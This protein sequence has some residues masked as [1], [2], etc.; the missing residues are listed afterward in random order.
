MMMFSHAPAGYICPF[1]LL[2]A[3][4]ENEH[5]LS[6]QADVF[7]RDDDITAFIAA[8][9]YPNN[10]GHVL[11]IPN[12]HVENIYTLP[13]DLTAKIHAFSRRV[14]LALKAVYGCDGVST[15]QHNEPCGYQDVWHYHLH[16]FARYAGDQLY[17][18][19]DEL[20]PPAERAVYAGKLRE[21]FARG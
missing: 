9:C 12:M 18:C 5:V 17:A 16:V 13:D 8:T 20:L 15:R 14:A 1:C 6:V 2:C 19:K 11:I 10:K 7:Y 3:G 4:I 21:Y